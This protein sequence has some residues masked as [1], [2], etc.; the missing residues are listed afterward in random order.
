MSCVLYDD[1]RLTLASIRIDAQEEG[2]GE[3]EEEGKG[4][5]GG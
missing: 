3:D 2:K 4:L 5:N 1:K